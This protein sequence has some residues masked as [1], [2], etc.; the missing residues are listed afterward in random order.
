MIP[1]TKFA[2][3][4]SGDPASGALLGRLAFAE[5]VVELCWGLGRENQEEEETSQVAIV[6]EEENSGLT[7]RNLIG[8]Y[9]QKR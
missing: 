9:S 8:C 3:G 7:L 1:S 6:V 4:Y 5:A 2:S